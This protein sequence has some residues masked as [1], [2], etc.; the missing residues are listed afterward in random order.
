M[1]HA[2]MYYVVYR[3]ILN[4]VVSIAEDNLEDSIKYLRKGFLKEKVFNRHTPDKNA[5]EKAN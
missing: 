3:S 4:N 2:C 1:F 5:L